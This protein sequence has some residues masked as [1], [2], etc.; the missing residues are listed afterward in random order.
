[1]RLGDLA[2]RG[3][4]KRAPRLWAT[5]AGQ[6]LRCYFLP[7]LE[8]VTKSL[9]ES[10]GPSEPVP[11]QGSRSRGHG[12]LPLA[13]QER[14]PTSSPGDPRASGTRKRMT[15]TSEEAA[16]QAD[17]DGT[18]DSAARLLR[19]SCLTKGLAPRPPRESHSRS[20]DARGWRGVGLACAPGR[21]GSITEAGR[22]IAR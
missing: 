20:R 21:H 15:L 19:R 5:A 9:E 13:G 14:E 3:E 4:R 16:P 22:E 7:G 12:A 10:P 2:L 6:A 18:A 8:K 11:T 1:M 17:G